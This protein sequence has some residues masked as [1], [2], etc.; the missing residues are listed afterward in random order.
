MRCRLPR[1]LLDEQHHTGSA[2]GPRGAVNLAIMAASGKGLGW[3]SFLSQAVAGVE[4]R[5]DNML[6]ETEDEHGTSTPSPAAPGP[7]TNPASPLPALPAI[8]D[9]SGCLCPNCR[10]ST[11]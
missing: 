10:A 9:S 1:Q 4:S 7:I 11:A 8:S 3:G 2:V 5:L 6:A